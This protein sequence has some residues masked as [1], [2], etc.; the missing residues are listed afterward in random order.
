MSVV[1]VHPQ[2]DEAV[3]LEDPTD[4][5]ARLAAALV[6][7]LPQLADR[8]VAEILRRDEGYQQASRVSL[9]DL[10]SSCQANLAQLLRKLVEPQRRDREYIGFLTAN[11]RRRFEQ[12]LPLESLLHAFRL[13][14]RVLWDALVEE[15]RRRDSSEIEA[16]LDSATRVWEMNDSSSSLVADGYRA[17]ET[18]LAWRDR[19]RR[20]ALVD[21][22]LQGRGAEPAFA[23][24]AATALRLPEAGGVAVVI[25]EPRDGEERALRG[26]DVALSGHGMTSVWRPEAQRE[27][28]IVGLA[29]TS[30]DGVAR[31]LR[32]HAVGRVGVSAGVVG[33]ADVPHAYR[34]AELAVQTIAPGE[35]DVALLEERLPSALLAASPGLT[36]LLVERVLGPVLALDDDDR[37]VLLDTLETYLQTGG[38]AAEAAKRLYCHRNTIQNRLHRLEGLTGHSLSDPDDLLGLALGIRA[39]R[40]WRG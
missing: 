18:E 22:L 9:E 11:G 39:Q 10:R 28:G 16:L 8:L 37:D 34:Q 4:P 20:H 23:R 29:G 35:T 32:P 13:G 30:A 14:G 24:E 31:T 7:R 40:L 33:L 3:V 12:G 15:A 1:S 6:D 38:S 2:T 21:A 27:V 5:I 19:E 17:A 36:R 25:A 26:A